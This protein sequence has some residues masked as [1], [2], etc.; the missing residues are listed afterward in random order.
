MAYPYPIDP[1]F[2]D[3]YVQHNPAQIGPFV[4][5][6]ARYIVLCR[7]SYQQ[8]RV[9]KSTDLGAT[10]VTQDAADGPTCETGPTC[11]SSATF[12]AGVIYITYPATAGGELGI[13]RFDCA[14]DQWIAPWTGG[15]ICLGAPEANGGGQT[16][17]S[18]ARRSDGS[19]VVL[20]DNEQPAAHDESVLAVTVSAAGVWGTPVVL[21]QGA[22]GAGAATRLRY[23]PEGLVIRA[24]DDAWCFATEVNGLSTSKMVLRVLEAAGTVD[25]PA[26]FYTVFSY[27]TFFLNV[28]RNGAPFISDTD[29]CIPIE[30]ITGGAQMP[31]MARAAA[32]D[33]STWAVEAIA[34][35]NTYQFPSNDVG[36][37]AAFA[38]DDKIVAVWWS[39][40]YD[41]LYKNIYDG[42]TWGVPTLLLTD[43]NALAWCLS[44]GYI[45]AEDRYGVAFGFLRFGNP[46]Y[47][48]EDDAPAPS[49]PVSSAKVYP[50]NGGQALIASPI[51][52]G[53]KR[54]IPKL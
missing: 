43:P 30:Q 3:T 52:V 15:P 23:G 40:S 4:N 2:G 39:G 41:K 33:P 47:Y 24:N 29:I 44:I 14:T 50:F 20:Y 25:P 11:A 26:S 34:P 1:S 7:Y 18:I 48:V 27:P 13:A 6:S 19:F 32:A 36:Q 8:L 46:G 42:S 16:Q 49:P 17:A 51:A 38:V 53:G 10:W 54:R 5:G 35:N 9:V 22:A 31:Y 37:I 21:F 45:E 12:H 28:G